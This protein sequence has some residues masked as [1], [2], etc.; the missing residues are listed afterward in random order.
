MKD[1][2]VTLSSFPN[3]HERSDEPYPSLN[4]VVPL[5]IFE[6]LD[7]HWPPV[8]TSATVS[9][10]RAVYVSTLLGLSSRSSLL[11]LHILNHSKRLND[12]ASIV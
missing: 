11:S 6:S 4:A 12:R 1:T 3:L 10:F 7:G 2:S 8:Q 9:S 5:T